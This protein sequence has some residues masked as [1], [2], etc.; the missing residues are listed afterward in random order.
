MP[1]TS[2]AFWPQQLSFKWNELDQQKQ[3]RSDFG[4][5][6]ITVM[7]AAFHILQSQWQTFQKIREQYLG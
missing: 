2:E 4:C 1:I 6:N 5:E 3:A 7:S